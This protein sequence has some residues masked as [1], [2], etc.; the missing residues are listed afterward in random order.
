MGK[1]VIVVASV[2]LV[3]IIAIACSQAK[4]DFSDSSKEDGELVGLIM[5]VLDGNHYDPVKVNDKFSQR[6]FDAFINN[7][8]PYKRYFS[9]QDIEKLREYRNKIDDEIQE[10]SFPLLDDADKIMKKRYEETEQIINNILKKEFDFSIKEEVE[11]DEEKLEYVKDKNE[12]K[13]RW[14]RILKYQ[15]LNRIDDKINILKKQ[16]EKNDSTY[17]AM[18]FKE[19]EQEAREKVT[20]SYSDLYQR[21][22]QLDYEDRKRVFINSFVE[23]F[24]PHTS[25]FPPKDK[26]DFDIGMSGQLEGIGATLTVKDGY[27]KVQSIVPGSASWKQGDL[28]EGDLILKVA[29]GKEEPV[30]IVNMRLD[31]S[32]RLI[33]GKKGT[34]VRLTVKK[35]DG[36]IQV[37]PIVRDVVVIEAGFA[38]S[39]VLEKDGKKLG[40]IHLP[41]FYADFGKINGRSCAK[42]IAEEVKKLKKEQV[43]G[44]LID[45]RNNGGGSLQDVVEMVGYFIPSGPVVQVKQRRSPAHGMRD[46]DNGKTLYDGPLLVLVNEYSASASEI[47]AAAIKDYKRGVIIGSR[48]TFGKGTVQRFINLDQF[49]PKGVSLGALKLTTQK[50]YRIN[51]E[52]TQLKGVEP[53]I[54]LPDA[55]MNFD[56]GERE[57]DEAM[58]WD[59]ISPNIY[60]EWKSQPNYSDLISKSNSR[61]SDVAYF[62]VMTEYAKW[63][64]AK[65]DDNLYP[66]DTLSFNNENAQYEKEDEQFDLIDDYKNSLEVNLLVRAPVTEKDSANYA[67]YESWG[68]LIEKDPYINESFEVFLDMINK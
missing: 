23:L 33:R 4:P 50:F 44:I 9:A 57:L 19:I 32:I 49:A 11:F 22:N 2:L 30:D 66:L 42:D 63:L 8:D 36:E 67:R 29:Q 54:V 35:L 3:T 43:E 10:K 64:K 24:D 31:E 38:K 14:R 17:K 62:K 20:K 39:S 1:R 53:H 60:R 28:K 13:D 51:G 7:L 58:K 65:S 55:Y 47:F 59:E 18:S 46:D 48:S 12:L 16:K 5:A 34:E 52:S 40:F 68:N 45:L 15:V 21:L 26:E 6:A 37:I 25:Y 27:V 56:L 61:V 41:K